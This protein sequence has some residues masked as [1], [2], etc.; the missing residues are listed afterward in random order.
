M[1]KVFVLPILALALVGC[2]P[3][4]RDAPS[5]P[6]LRIG[7]ELCELVRPGMTV[8]EVEAAIGGPP[9]FYE[10]TVGVAY[11][12]GT[13]PRSYKTDQSWSGRRG[14]VEVQFDAAGKAVKATWHPAQDVWLR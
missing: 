8:A 5:R 14:T 10:G 4:G 6:D 12:P 9:G 2:E 7:P 11:V 3:A 13:G 1:G